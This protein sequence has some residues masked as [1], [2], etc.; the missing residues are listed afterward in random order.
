MCKS[1][2]AF[3]FPFE[4]VS[5]I[6]GWGEDFSSDFLSSIKWDVVGCLGGVG[7]LLFWVFSW[8]GGGFCFVGVVLGGGCCGGWFFSFWCVWFVGGGFGGGVLLLFG[9][10]FLGWRPPELILR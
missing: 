2:D 7:G 4:Y 9:F 10:F 1:F 5:F 8:L 3:F 6:D